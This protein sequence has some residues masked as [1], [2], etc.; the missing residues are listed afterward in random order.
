MDNKSITGTVLSIERFSLHDGPGLR[1]TV[2]LKGCPL[3]CMWCHNPESQAFKPEL[4][5]DNEKCTSCGLCGK[6]CENQTQKKPNRENCMACGKCVAICPQSA[7]EIKG[8][9]M[10]A[11]DVMSEVQKDMIYYNYS[12]GGLTISG[13]EPLAQFEFT[14]E[15]LRLAKDKGIHTCIETSG[16]GPTE[17]LLALLPDLFLYDFK[18]SDDEK[19]IK[20]VGAARELIEKNLYALD[21][22]GAKIILRCPIIPTC[23]ARDDHFAAIA[24][25]ANALSNIVEI[26]IMPYHPMGAAKAA[27]LGR[28]YPLAGISFPAE[29]EIDGWV[30]KVRSGTDVVVR[31][32]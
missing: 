16:H 4:L 20:Y 12:G 23:N 31:R 8:S 27:R 26:N 1:T 17:K 10:L 29:D 14:R 28:E 5:Y 19:H 22:A 13:G 3:A 25:T 11:Q 32:G 15:L 18:E 2:F 21:A 24:K 30:E 7:L 9:A 6:V